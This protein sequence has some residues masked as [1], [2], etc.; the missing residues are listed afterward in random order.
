MH[1]DLHSRLGQLAE[2]IDE[3]LSNEEEALRFD[4]HLEGGFLIRNATL[5][6]GSN[7]LD[8]ES[9]DVAGDEHEV[10]VVPL[11]RIVALRIA[12]P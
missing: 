8:D 2:E 11:Y 10:W 9:I 4:L 5:I 12:Y 7:A 1:K 6:D 3:R